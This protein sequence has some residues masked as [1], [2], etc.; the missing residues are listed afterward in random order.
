MNFVREV[1][2]QLFNK[3]SEVDDIQSI[4]GGCIHQA[5]VFQFEGRIFF[6]KWNSGSADMFAKEAK[7]LN[8]L[9]ETNSLNIPQVIGLGTVNEIDYLCLEYIESATLSNTFW[10]DFGKSLA[11]LHSHTASTFGLEFDNYIGSLFQSNQPSVEWIEFFI[12][13]RLQ[14]L[15]RSARDKSLIGSNL[16]AEFELLCNDLP[17]LIPTEEPALLHGDLWSGNFLAGNIGQPVVFD[18]AVYYGHREAEL[19]FTRMFGGFAPTFYHSYDEAFPLQDGFE[20]R[21]DLFNLYPLLVHLNLFGASYL[22][23]IKQTLSRFV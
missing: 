6:L 7:G 20:E 21:V 9:G 23:G 13:Q 8:L 22:S 12:Q 18:P 15:I 10:E 16:I 11:Q 2:C 5:G 4:G 3:E 14:P 19:A 1:V 17:N